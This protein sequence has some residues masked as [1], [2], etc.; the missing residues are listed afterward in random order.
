MEEFDLG[1]D[2]IEGMKEILELEKDRKYEED[3]ES[4]PIHRLEWECKACGS[5]RCSGELPE[6][7]GCMLYEVLNRKRGEK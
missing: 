7:K 5:Q 6:A 4:K 1:K 3:L 2:L